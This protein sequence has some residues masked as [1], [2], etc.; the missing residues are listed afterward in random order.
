VALAFAGAVIVG[1]EHGWSVHASG[2]TGDVLTFFG[3]L[4]LALYTV[5][6]KRVAM[7]HSPVP[8]S[9]FSNFVAALMALPITLWQVNL[10]IRTGAWH[11]IGWQGWGA[12]LYM[13]VLASAVGYLLYF[14]ALRYMTPARL[15]SVSYLQPVGATLLAAMLLAEPLTLRVVTGGILILAGVYAIQSRTSGSQAEEEPA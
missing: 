1:A 3:G 14:W 11:R 9:M 8:V 4:G 6:G 10:L 2:V 12:V 7:A 5:L 15:G 13:G